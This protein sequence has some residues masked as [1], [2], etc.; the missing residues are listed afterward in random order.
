MAAP[1]ASGAS[2]IHS[3][4]R[5]MP[6]P[7]VR[8]SVIAGMSRAESGVGVGR[9][10]ILAGRAEPG[11]GARAPYLAQQR[12]ARGQPAA[13]APPGLHDVGVDPARHPPQLL[14]DPLAGRV[15]PVVRLGAHVDLHPRLARDRVHRQAALYDAD[16]HV[17][18][19]AP[20]H[21]GL[22]RLEQR[23]HRR[24]P[25]AVAPRVS[26]GPAVRDDVAGRRD[27]DGDDGVDA[28]PLERHDR[29]DGVLVQDGA[30][31]A[32]VAEALLADGRGQQ[33]RHRRRP[34]RPRQQ[35]AEADHGRERHAVVADA[36][37]VQAPAL[38]PRLADRALREH[39]VEVRRNHDRGPVT[40]D[41]R[42][43]VAGLVAGRLETART[44]QLGDCDRARLLRERRSGDRAERE[45]VA[46]EVVEHGE[47][48]SGP[49]RLATPRT[50]AWVRP[51]A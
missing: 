15:D 2:S 26:A 35:P 9:G 8:P 51:S 5:W 14:L 20:G 32:Q 21:R 23:M 49:F 6:A 29:G 41:P 37:P 46:D 22:P 47:A 27:P 25:V 34:P 24:R 44:E 16:I 48:G 10:G 28:V 7:R 18:G 45:G 19:C 42:Q 40:A 1:P 11:A 4:S 31:A 30:D 43:H 50:L 38:A 17:G 3:S 13:G 36:R 12:M 33:H 39:G